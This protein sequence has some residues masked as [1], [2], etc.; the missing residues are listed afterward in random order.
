MPGDSSFKQSSEKNSKKPGA[1]GPGFRGHRPLPTHTHLGTDVAKS[2]KKRSLQHMI[3]VGVLKP[4]EPDVDKRRKLEQTAEQYLRYI[5]DE[6][7]APPRRRRQAR[8]RP[9]P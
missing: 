3:D 8:P 1:L 5:L 4:L 7:A 6:R 2:S 9:E